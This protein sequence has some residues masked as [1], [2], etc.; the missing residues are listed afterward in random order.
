MQIMNNEFVRRVYKFKFYITVFRGQFGWFTGWLPEIVSVGVLL[1]F[2]GF[3]LSRTQVVM[4]APVIL[5]LMAVC[6]FVWYKLGFWSVESVVNNTKDPVMSEVFS[7]A[8]KIN[9]CEEVKL[10]VKGGGE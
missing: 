4:M 2:F 9:S 8:K 6:G 10:K 5:L 7:A 1:H 3:D